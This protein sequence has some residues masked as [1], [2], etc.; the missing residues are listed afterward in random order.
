MDTLLQSSIDA[1]HEALKS[2]M[3]AVLTWNYGNS[4]LAADR[5]LKDKNS[6]RIFVGFNPEK[7]ADDT[8]LVGRITDMQNITIG[9]IVNYACHPTDAC[10]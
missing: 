10:I 4:S 3:P 2:A 7:K 9:T 8:L 1:I 6:R 5:D